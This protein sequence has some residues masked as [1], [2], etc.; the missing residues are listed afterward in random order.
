MEATAGY[1]LFQTT[2]PWI[3]SGV[4]AIF[5]FS[6][7]PQAPGTCSNSGLGM[8][9]PGHLLLLLVL[10]APCPNAPSALHT[11]FWA[12]FWCFLS[13]LRKCDNA[14]CYS[15]KC[16]F[17]EFLRKGGRRE[18]RTRGARC[19]CPRDPAGLRR[20]RCGRQGW[21]QA[22]PGPEHLCRQWHPLAAE[23][24]QGTEGRKTPPIMRETGLFPLCQQERGGTG[25]RGAPWS[26]CGELEAAGISPA[27]HPEQGAHA[28][29]WKTSGT[30]SQTS[31]VPSNSKE[32]VSGAIG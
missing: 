9:H 7:S 28:N 6:Q 8:E 13:F 23:R 17:G 20:G 1:A 25:A 21:C 24:H 18:R 3:N 2:N 22:L 29:S 12:N 16:S 30:A 5:S 14:L 27:G 31:S 4:G 10:L 11:N 19:E 26:R 15:R 32:K